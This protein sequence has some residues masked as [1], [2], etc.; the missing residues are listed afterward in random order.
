MP[1][2]SEFAPLV[3]PRRTRLLTMIITVID[4][5]D[6]F[7]G[8]AAPAAQAVAAEDGCGQRRDLEADAGIGA[9]SAQPRS[10]EKSG[11]RAQRARHDIGQADDAADRD[12]DIVR[13]SPRAAGRQHMPARA[14][15]GED[16]VR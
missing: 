5:D 14:R 1:S 10:K 6:R 15:P 2:S 3:M 4:A 13:G 8:R 9:G 11:K 12:A 16:Q 7:R